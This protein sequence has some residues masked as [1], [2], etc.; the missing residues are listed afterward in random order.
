LPQ[1]RKIS[2]TTTNVLYNALWFTSSGQ[3]VDWWGCERTNGTAILNID[4]SSSFT[5]IAYFVLNNHEPEVFAGCDITIK[6]T[7]TGDVIFKHS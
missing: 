7:E 2:I 3:Y 1:S 4:C 6:D 5:N